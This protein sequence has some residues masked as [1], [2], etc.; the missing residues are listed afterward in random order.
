[1]MNLI[2]P[3]GSV[4]KIRNVDNPV[5]IFGY[6]QQSAA[7]P[8]G[9]VDYVGVPYPLGNVNV[10]LQLGFQMTDITEVLFEGYRTEAFKPVE[11]LLTLRRAQHEAVSGQKR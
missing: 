9:L 11:V 8:E 3:I 10:S 4:V 1:M 6:L 2:L 5:M 7:R